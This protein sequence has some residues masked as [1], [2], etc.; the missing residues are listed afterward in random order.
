MKDVS[1]HRYLVPRAISG[2][3]GRVAGRGVVVVVVIVVAGRVVV[4]GG[5]AVARG[6]RIVAEA[7]NTNLSFIPFFE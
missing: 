7:Q 3:G 2:R 4:V 5:G 1:P 6:R